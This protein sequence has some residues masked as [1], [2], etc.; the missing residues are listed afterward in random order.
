MILVDL[1]GRTFGELT[2]TGRGASRGTCVTYWTCTCACGAIVDVDAA[3]LKRGK[4]TS[5]GHVPFALAEGRHLWPR[6]PRILVGADGSIVG[7]RGR[8]LVPWLDERGYLRVGTYQ[9]DGVKR[10]YQPFVHVVVCETFHGPRP[11][12]MQAAHE[13]GVPTNCAADNLSW[14]TPTEN[15]AD[16]LRHGTRPQGERV[17]CAKLTEQDVIAIRAAWAEGVTLSEIK[18]RHPVHLSTIS[19]IVLRKTWRHV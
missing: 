16:K 8:L 14:K 11:P 10:P 19:K 1:A 9:A 18:A 7:V 4:R 15:E 6:D 3:M 5:C 2:V 17:Y 12:G 13:D